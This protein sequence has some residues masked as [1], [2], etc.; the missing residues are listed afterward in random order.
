MQGQ[1]TPEVANNLNVVANPEG[2]FGKN[3]LQYIPKRKKGGVKS[4]GEG[5]YD[6]INGYSGI[7]ANGG[8]KSKENSWLNKYK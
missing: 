7:F 8:T 4:Q 6:Y 1:L 3:Q 5:Y 2:Y